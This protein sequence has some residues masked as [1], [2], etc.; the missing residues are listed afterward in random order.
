MMK[1]L[2]IANWKM[3][4]NSL[5]EARE[6]F[7]ATIKTAAKIKTAKVIIC[8]PFVYLGLL[9]TKVKPLS[10]KGLTFVGLGSQDVFWEDSG[11]FTGE[12]SAKMLKNLGVQ[13]VIIGHSERRGLGETDEMVNKKIKQALANNLKVIF[14]VGE[15]TR[16]ESGAHFQFIKDEIKN[17]LEK[18]PAKFLRNLIVAYEPVWAISSKSF[19]GKAKFRAD[20]PDDAFQMAT[21]IKR[22][23]VSSYGKFS[24]RVPVL[25]GGSVDASNARTFLEK[26]NVDGLLVGRASWNA[27]TFKEL[28]MSIN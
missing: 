3:T 7:S 21:Y 12:I 25:Y 20:T 6:L 2:I 19:S 15:K 14:C 24:R 18:I 1:K 5:K 28:L 4:P 23:F 17:G 8:P 10:N 13:Y 22:I 9:A 26:G 11:S 27:K 16:D